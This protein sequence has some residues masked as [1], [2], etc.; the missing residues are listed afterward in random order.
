MVNNTV[1]SWLDAAKSQGIDSLDADL[2]L[3]SA[4]GQEDRTYLVTHAEVLLPEDVLNSVNEMLTRRLSGEPLAQILGYREFYGRKFIVVDGGIKTLI[5]RPESEANVDLAISVQPESV[6]DV[7]T[8]SGVLALTIAAELPN[9]KVVACDIEP[10][11]E[12]IF[13]KNAKNIGFFSE[14]SYAPELPRVQFVVSDL[15]GNID[16]KFD[17]IVANLP[18]VDKDWDWLDKNALSYEPDMALYAE[19]KG[20]FL[21]KKLI[22][23]IAEK[24][25]SKY[26]I[27]EAD[28]CQFQ[29]I[30]DYARGFGF[31]LLEERSFSL[32]FTRQ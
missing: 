32:L 27:L 15:L 8:G 4:L 31:T 9:T 21:I 25:A 19:D 3:L 28:P 10:K 2:I 6:L 16:A 14:K 20:L 13:S 23:Q 1:H 30:I 24:D 17:V 26:L 12:E 11:Y 18:Y 22:R 29:D 5:P 7:G